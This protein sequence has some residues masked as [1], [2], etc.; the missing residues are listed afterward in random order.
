ME[1]T[2]Q[3]TNDSCMIDEVTACMHSIAL[4][5]DQL[6]TSES[7]IFIVHSDICMHI[8]RLHFLHPII[9]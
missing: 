2:Q 3:L 6:M 9:L 4:D 7:M 5:H 8:F 1:S